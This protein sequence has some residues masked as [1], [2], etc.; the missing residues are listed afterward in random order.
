MALFLI[1]HVQLDRAG[2][3]ARVR[4]LAPDYSKDSFTSKFDIVDVGEV[5]TALDRGDIVE[6][7]F[8]GPN[9]PVPGGRVSKETASEWR[10]NDRRNEFDTGADL[11]RP[12]S[13]LAPTCWRGSGAFILSPAS[14]D[15]FAPSIVA[16][17]HVT[18]QLA[19]RYTH[20]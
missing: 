18:P 7:R 3:V 6:L 11:A 4:W 1:T 20:R 5:V 2:E 16:A 9:G 19:P 15:V 17:P 13:D 12:A 8:D 14:C 10:G